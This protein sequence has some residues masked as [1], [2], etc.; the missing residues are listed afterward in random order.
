MDENEIY[1]RLIEYCDYYRVPKEY[2]FDILEDQKV[3]PMIRGKAT[4][5]QVYTLLKG[6]LNPHE[7]VVSK[8]N[9]NAQTGMHDEDVTITHQRTGVII[10][11]ECKNASRGSM[12]TGSNRAQIAYR[13][14][15]Y[16]TIKCHKS[17]SD[18]SKAST[19]NDRYLVGDFD[20]VISNMSNAVIAGATYSEKF[21]LIDDKDTI[22]KLAEYYHCAAD[23]D[24]IFDCSFNDW[25]FAFSKDIAVDGVIPRTPYVLLE[26]DTVWK[27]ISSIADN[28][29]AFARSKRSRAT[30]R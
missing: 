16:C 11:V 19:T 12:K 21:E 29:E 23:Y 26:N 22:N 17:R 9:L 14:K 25:R 4:E 28:L 6:I 5:Y 1:K 3:V 13:G 20:I 7:W 8:L 27:P 2:L 10:K 15:T 18:L 30:R 24:S